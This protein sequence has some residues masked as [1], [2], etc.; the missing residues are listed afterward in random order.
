MC[1]VISYIGCCVILVVLVILVVGYCCS[2]LL[3]VLVSSLVE[4]CICDVIVWFGL[5]GVL[6][7]LMACWCLFMCSWRCG[8]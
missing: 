3:I 5:L 1:F 7:C 8:C 4:S 6:L 2:D